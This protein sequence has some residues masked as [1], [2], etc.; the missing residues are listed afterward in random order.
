MVINEEEVLKDELPILDIYFNAP[1]KSKTYIIPITMEILHEMM[2][3]TKVSLLDKDEKS[4]RYFLDSRDN[5]EYKEIPKPRKTEDKKD[6]VF[7]SMPESGRVLEKF[8]SEDERVILDLKTPK[9]ENTILINY[10]YWVGTNFNDLENYILNNIKNNKNNSYAMNDD[11]FNCDY[12][13]NN[14]NGCYIDRSYMMIK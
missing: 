13:N 11:E 7:I 1:E 6:F 2:S 10:K 8:I 9:N 5:F 14:F 12:Y 4:L 3:H